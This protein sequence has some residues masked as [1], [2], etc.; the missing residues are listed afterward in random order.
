[1]TSL[2]A[3]QKLFSYRKKGLG[4]VRR[5]EPGLQLGRDADDDGEEEDE[6]DGRRHLDRQHVVVEL[7]VVFGIRRG[8]HHGGGRQHTDPS[9]SAFPP[10]KFERS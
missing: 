9:S 5:E 6:P 2:R 4:V 10:R 8:N 7:E 1:M 3:D